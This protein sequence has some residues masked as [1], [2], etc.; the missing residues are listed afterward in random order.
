MVIL[1]LMSEKYVNVLFLTWSN[2]LV[3][4]YRH[5]QTYSVS[6][7]FNQRMSTTTTKTMT[8]MATMRPTTTITPSSAPVVTGSSGTSNGLLEFL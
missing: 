5:M 2:I 1:Y 3:G 6:A 7:G 4:Q 8:P